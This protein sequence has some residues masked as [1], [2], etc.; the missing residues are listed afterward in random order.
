MVLNNKVAV[1]TGAASGI[2]KAIA[3]AFAGA[4][5]RVAVADLD[6][7]KAEEAAE[8]INARGGTAVAIAMDVADEQSVDTGI[9]RIAADWGGIDVLVSNAGLQHIEAVDKLSY[10]NW[11]KV[12]GVHLDGAFLTS[13]ACLRH[14]YR[15]QCGG[16]LLFMGSVHSKAASPLKA[17][18]VA[19]K[20]ALL[21]LARTIAVEGAKYGVRTNVICPG[22]VLT[23]LAEKQIPE[24]ARDLG[25]SEEDVIKNVMLKGTVDGE[26]TTTG[27]VAELAVFLAAFPSNALTGQ[28]IIASHGWHME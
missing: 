9:D 14:M 1:I 5:A 8:T 16:T 10:T 6:G 28:S 20:H 2:G 15:L 7:A 22:F 3:E 13:R 17:P 26:F 25:I 18:Y 11:K 21:G 24:Q 27:D 23:P 12:T 4:G 19:S